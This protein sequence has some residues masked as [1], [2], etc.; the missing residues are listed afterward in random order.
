MRYGALVETYN[1]SFMYAKLKS[2]VRFAISSLRVS[3]NE[4]SLLC[5]SFFCQYRTYR[6]RSSWVGLSNKL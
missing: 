3:G 6:T 4:I 1:A 2:N 5:L